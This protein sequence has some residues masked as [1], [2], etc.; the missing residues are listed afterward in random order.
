[1]F[2]GKHYAGDLALVY[3]QIKTVAGG[4]I[5]LVVPGGKVDVGL[6]G[7]QG[8]NS[9]KADKLGIVVQQMGNL[10]IMAEHDINV[11]QSRVFTL[12]GGNIVAWSSKGDIDAGKGAK[13]VLSAPAPITTVDEKGNVKTEFPPIISGSGIQ[14]IGGGNVYLAAPVGVV[15]AGEAGISGGQVIIAATAVIGASNIQASG[16]T[17]GVPTAVA[18]PVVPT[19][20]DGAATSAAKSA[21]ES[22]AAGN[23]DSKDAAG[24]KKK[25]S[26]AMLSADV[27]GYGQCSVSDVKEGKAGCGG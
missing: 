4:D 22:T 3:S 13:S 20:A 10:N 17:I 18:A 14:A 15:D 6:A 5:N 11:N 25:S 2:P 12:G 27:V 24:D 9:K 26:V 7:N 8:G 1:L 19:G 16:G 21:G 23:K